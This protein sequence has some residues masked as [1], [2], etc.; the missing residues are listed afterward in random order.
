MVGRMKDERA[1][2][3][4]TSRAT[5]HSEIVRRSEIV[6]LFLLVLLAGCLRIP[7]AFSGTISHFDEGVY[8]LW[9][10]VGE[11]P[12]EVFYAPPLYPLLLKL[13]FAVVGPD[14]RWAMLLSGIV[15]TMTVPVCWWI[16][17]RWYGRAA[18]AGTA[19]LAAFSMFH[20]AFSHMALTDALFLFWF[21]TAIALA[22][23]AFVPFNGLPHREGNWPPRITPKCWLLVILAGLVVGLAMNTKYN[24]LLPLLI[25]SAGLVMVGMRQRWLGGGWNWLGAL[26]VGLATL[27]ALALYAPWFWEVHSEFG[28]GSLPPSWILHWAIRVVRESTDDAGDSVVFGPMSMM[29]PS[30][31]R[32]H[33]GVCGQRRQTR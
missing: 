5:V 14:E 33:G 19:A 9:G 10:M 32:F 24:G 30:P 3:V 4:M 18:A 16:G 12:A 8:V 1:P 15:G 28:Y 13:T 21:L 11:F 6:W 2:V 26:A 31:R 17:R 29:G 25:C 22:T 7:P 27:I 23:E 20:V